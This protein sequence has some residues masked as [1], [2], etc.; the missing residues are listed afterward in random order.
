MNNVALKQ[1]L[2]GEQLSIVQSEVESK[3]KNKVIMYLLW[4]FTGVV[5]GHR[6][7]LGDIGMGLGMLFTLGGLGVWALIDVF[8]IGK[9]LEKKNDNLERDVIQQ[10]KAYNN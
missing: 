9:R 8:F 7:Y 3:G 5:G 10:V 2:T 4:W 6:F 1:G